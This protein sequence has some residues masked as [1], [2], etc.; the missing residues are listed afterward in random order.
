MMK[1]KV[2][3][4]KVYENISSPHLKL[5]IDTKNCIYTYGTMCVTAVSGYTKAH[6]S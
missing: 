1:M 3:S 6:P 2:Y 4:I 5:L